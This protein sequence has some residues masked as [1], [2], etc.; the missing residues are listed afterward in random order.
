MPK[1]MSSEAT[2]AW[3]K[4]RLRKKR[5]GSI[6]AARA[7]LPDDEQRDEERPGRQRDDDLR[8]G[9]AGA[10]AADETPD[11]PQEAHA[12]RA[13][14]PAGR[15][16]RRGPWLSASRPR[17]SGMRMRPMGTFSQKIHCHERPSTTAPPT[18]GPS[19]TARPPTPPQAPRARPRLSRRHRRREQRQRERRH[20]GAAEALHRPGGD[21]GLD[22]GGEGRR[23]R[24]DREDAEADHEQPP[25]AEPVAERRAGEEQDREGE[26]VGVHR[27]L[28]PLERRVQLVSDHRERRGHDEV[29]ERDHEEG[30]RRQRERPQRGRPGRP[31]RPSARTHDAPPRPAAPSGAASSRKSLRVLASNLAGGAIALTLGIQAASRPT[32]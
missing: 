2:L 21:E 15:A 24:G 27:P 5:I 7:E 23:R 14:G 22:R 26:R 19:A 3:A 28:Q 17:A 6:G 18:S 10:V 13:R 29:V 16:A 4:V 30:E 20:D 32:R 11:D 1:N 9:P 31:T 25:A 8:A 12:R